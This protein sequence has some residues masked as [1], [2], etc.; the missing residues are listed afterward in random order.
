MTAHKEN[1][2][3]NAQIF[4]VPTQPIYF[5]PSI[6]RVNLLTQF[7]KTRVKSLDFSLLIHLRKGTERK[8]VKKKGIKKKRK[9]N[10]SNIRN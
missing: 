1:K 2:E 8:T 5:H 4:D 10:A 6:N 9:E 3:N 7:I